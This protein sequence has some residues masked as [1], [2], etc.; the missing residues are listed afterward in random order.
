MIMIKLGSKRTSLRSAQDSRIH[1]VQGSDERE[2]LTAK[3][4]L[5]VD[6]SL[7]EDGSLPRQDGVRDKSGSILIDEPNF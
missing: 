5:E 2:G 3:I 1:I 7:G 6:G 4:L